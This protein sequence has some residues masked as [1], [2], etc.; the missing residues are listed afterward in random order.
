MLKFLIAHTQSPWENLSFLSRVLRNDENLPLNEASKWLVTVQFL[1]TW[2]F[3]MFPMMALQEENCIATQSYE[4]HFSYCNSDAT[5]QLCSCHRCAFNFATS[6]NWLKCYLLQDT[7]SRMGKLQRA[8]HKHIKKFPLDKHLQDQK[9]VKR[10]RCFFEYFTAA[11]KKKN[12]IRYSSA[13]FLC[14]SRHIENFKVVS[15]NYPRLF[16]LCMFLFLC[17]C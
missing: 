3:M 5:L 4:I 2:P 17:V 14:D 10:L 12:P 13:V 9:H 15:R 7:L 11:E 1:A 8:Y 6:S 16:H